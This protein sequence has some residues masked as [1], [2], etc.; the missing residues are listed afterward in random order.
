MLYQ[1]GRSLHVFLCVCAAPRAQHYGAGCGWNGLHIRLEWFTHQAGMAVV[2]LCPLAVVSCHRMM[3]P[4]YI[5]CLVSWL[6]HFGSV[7]HLSVEQVW[8]VP[9][10]VTVTKL[11]QLPA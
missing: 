6:G 4:S 5:C 7:Q 2:W 9:A 3:H 10:L 8:I 1:L 11:V